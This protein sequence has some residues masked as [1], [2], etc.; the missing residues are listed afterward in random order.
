MFNQELVETSSVIVCLALN[1]NNDIDI[2]SYGIDLVLL[3]MSNSHQGV[4]LDSMHRPKRDKHMVEYDLKTGH[5][6]V[7]NYEIQL[8]I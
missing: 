3:G 1:A 6:K 7:Y 8:A 5:H 2:M 4:R